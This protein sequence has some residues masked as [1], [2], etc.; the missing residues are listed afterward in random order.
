MN[1]KK[2]EDCAF[3]LCYRL[4]HFILK[5]VR[6]IYRFGVCFTASMFRTRVVARNRSIYQ[7]F[8]TQKAC[9]EDGS[10]LA[11]GV[12]EFASKVLNGARK[13]ELTQ[14]SFIVVG[15]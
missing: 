12:S 8:G 4:A 9:Q 7:I 3:H 2:V 1:C 10:S 6:L 5:Q 15:F 11:G 13:R 14:V